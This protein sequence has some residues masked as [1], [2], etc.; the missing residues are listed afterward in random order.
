METNTLELTEQPEGLGFTSIRELVNQALKKNFGNKPTPD[1]ASTGFAALDKATGGLQKGQLY[2]I[3]VRPGMGKTAF[4]LSLTNN[5]AVKDDYSVAIFSSERSNMKMTNR[6]IE[7][8]T[9]MSLDKLQ[10]G[11]FKDS[12]R[13]HMLSLLSNI[14]KAKIY[15]DDTP[16]LSVELLARKAKYL[17]EQHQV[18][19]IIVDYLELLTTK[20]V[21]V[22]D[23][24]SQ[25]MNM[26]KSIKSMATELDLPVL[27]FSQVAVPVN[28]KTPRPAISDL[29]EYIQQDSDVLM[30]LHRNDA[31]PQ[32]EHNKGKNAV[33]LV[34]KTNQSGEAQEEVVLPMTFIESIAKFADFS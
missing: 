15:L 29:P 10:S 17:K 19:L 6:L 26:V 23:R 1:G 30:M 21:D 5:M 3:A 7:S 8:E 33:E 22:D 12:E 9:G 13:D 24:S 2:T 32:P 16:A 14:A 18:D 25:Y 34:V 4:L 28:G 31:F 20:D 11:T 27:L